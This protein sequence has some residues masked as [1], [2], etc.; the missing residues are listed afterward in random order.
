VASRFASVLVMCLFVGPVSAQKAPP[1]ATA[2]RAA[3][4][5][6]AI[7]DIEAGRRTTPLV[8]E[9]TARGNAVVTFLARRA[10]GR[11]PRIV[12]DVTG[13]GDLVDGTFDLKVGTMTRVG[14]TDWYSLTTGVA[15]GARI[16][17]LIAYAPGDYRPDPCNPRRPSLRGGGPASEF[18]VPGYAPPPEF[19]DPPVAPAGLVSDVQVDSRALGGPRPATVYTPPGYRRDGAYPL[20]V[21]HDGLNVA[22]LAQAPRVL[23]WLIARKAIEPLV[24]VF[25]DTWPHSGDERMREPIRTFLTAEVPSWLAAR[26]GVTT[27]A[28]SRAIL[29]VSFAA[30]DVLDAAVNGAAFDH[31]GLLIPGRRLS[32]ADIAAMAAHPGRRLQVTILAGRYDAANLPTARQAR[33]ALAGA[34]HAVDYIDVPEGHNMATWRNHLGEVLVSLF[35]TAGGGRAPGAR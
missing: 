10:D 11:L 25:V 5:E 15:P 17:Y 7:A 24:A 1:A 30:K 16:E 4:P 29:G 22:R 18:V 32:P 6:A 34:G 12:S 13:W 35:G 31:V 27:S 2:A 8:E 20:A 14:R 23:D 9:P 3:V 33:Q 28:S 21:F 26:Y 19:E